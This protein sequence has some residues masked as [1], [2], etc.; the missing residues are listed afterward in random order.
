MTTPA[1]LAN[2]TVG[3]PLWPIRAK[4][5]RADQHIEVLRQEVEGF[6]QNGPYTPRH[7]LDAQA[8]QYVWR[9]DVSRSPDPGWAINV[10]EAIHHLHTI[11]DHIAWLVAS[12]HSGTPPDGTGFPVYGSRRSFRNHWTRNSGYF[13]VRGMPSHAQAIIEDVQPY[14]RGN[15]YQGHPLWVLRDL[16]NT[17]KH[18]AL[19]TVGSAAGRGN[20]TVT[21]EGGH[22]P[23]KQ[24]K[25]INGPFEHGD[26]V[27]R[28]PLPQAG[29]KG[30]KIELNVKFAFHVAL[31]QAGPAGGRELMHL[32]VDLRNEVNNIVRRLTPFAA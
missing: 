26:V 12:A 27:A 25:F 9:V 23:V 1:Y 22:V 8:G 3:H 13:Q 28:W 2:V 14:H 10:S 20:V 19:V 31:P 4:L 15:G 32:L 24:V 7:E 29:P 11:L 16:A 17:D 5:S 30:M 21:Q 18:Q 6:L